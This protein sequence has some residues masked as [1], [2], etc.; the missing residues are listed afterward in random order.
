MK[1]ALFLLVMLAGVL[2]MNAQT[3]TI[4]DNGPF[5]TINHQDGDTILVGKDQV[6]QVIDHNS[7]VFLMTSRKWSP[8]PLT[9]IISLKATDYGYSTTGA[10]RSYLA[11]I[12]FE[13]YKETYAYT[14]GNLDTVKFYYGTSLQHMVVYTYDDGTVVTKQYVN[15]Q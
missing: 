4:V 14:S 13:A 11:T 5:I 7:E 1:R 12:C 3:S 9:K 2:A 10:L 6:V 15:S 8:G